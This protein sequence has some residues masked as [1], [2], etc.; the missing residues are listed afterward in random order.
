MSPE[1]LLRKIKVIITGAT[2]MIGESV[3]D[4]C[5]KHDLVDRVLIINRRPSGLQHS[6]LNEIVLDDLSKSS[7]IKE[8][9]LG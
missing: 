7:T 6:K 9:L 4:Q 3:L 5:L 2:G 8:S 1:K